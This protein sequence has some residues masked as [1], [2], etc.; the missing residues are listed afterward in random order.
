MMTYFVS[1]VIPVLLLILAVWFMRLQYRAYFINWREEITFRKSVSYGIPILIKSI[2]IFVLIIL[3]HNRFHNDQKLELVLYIALF[4]I[5]SVI[6]SAYS[7]GGFKSRVKV[8]THFSHKY[9]NKYSKEADDFIDK[10]RNAS[11]E[12]YSYLIRILLLIAFITTFLPNIGLFVASNIA[13]FLFIMSL[14][15]LSV[16]LNNLIYFGFISLMIFQFDPVTLNI[17]HSNHIVLALSYLVI[18][19]GLII[20]TRLDNR[21]FSMVGNRAIKNVDF[22]KGYVKVYTGKSTLVYQNILNRYYYVYFRK[23]GIVIMFESL[24]DAKL[25]KAIVK[26]MI[27]KGTQYLQVNEEAL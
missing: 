15:L 11:F 25:T 6:Q 17:I 2:V 27:F 5:F 19:V 1:I 22:K 14:I 4:I 24:Y 21:M 3:I 9:F 26:K 13:V 7:T 18:L 8:I 23:H 20:E 16:M 10:I 12:R